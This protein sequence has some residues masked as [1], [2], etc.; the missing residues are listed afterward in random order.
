MTVIPLQ[1]GD[2]RRC[3][4]AGRTQVVAGDCH[5]NVGGAVTHAAL[6]PSQILYGRQRFPR[7]LV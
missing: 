4:L 5:S 3:C 2:P 1:R 7:S 6:L